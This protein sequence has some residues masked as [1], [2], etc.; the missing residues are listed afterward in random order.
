L[1]VGD[2]I[3]P[4]FKAKYDA[5]VARHKGILDVYQFEYDLTAAEQ[6]FFRSG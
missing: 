4:N 3:S 2:I 6:E 1:R 5:L